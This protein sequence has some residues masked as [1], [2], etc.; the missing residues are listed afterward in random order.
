MLRAHEAMEER[1]DVYHPKAGVCCLTLQT[2]QSAWSDSE[3]T[4]YRKEVSSVRRGPEPST[5]EVL[6]SRE[7]GVAAGNSPTP[8]PQLA[9]LV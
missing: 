7:A 9:S 3:Q 2:Q 6:P 5:K 4:L 8:L 1:S